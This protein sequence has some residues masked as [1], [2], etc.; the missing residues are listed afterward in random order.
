M[1]VAKKVQAVV[2]VLV[3]VLAAGCTATK[4]YTSKLFPVRATTVKDSSLAKAP[5]FLDMETAPGKNDWVSTDAIMG[6]DT[7][8]K[9]TALDKLA[10]VYPPGNSPADSN[11][12]RPVIQ[13]N[14]SPSEP[15][16]RSAN[17][18]EVRT[19]RVRED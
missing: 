2:P 7:V 12:R 15:V 5:R 6:R 13:T 4:V 8:S 11:T 14:P 10:K 9:T 19:K 1:Q 18:G 17:P 3:M 16:A